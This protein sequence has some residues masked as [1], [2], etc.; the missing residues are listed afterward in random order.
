MIRHIPCYMYDPAGNSQ[1][2]LNAAS[3]YGF[4]HFV[5]LAEQIVLEL[6]CRGLLSCTTHTCL[7]QELCQMSVA[8]ALSDPGEVVLLKHRNRSCFFA[9]SGHAVGLV[10]ETVGRQDG[11]CGG[12]HIAYRSFQSNGVQAGVTAMYSGLAPDIRRLA[13]RVVVAVM[14]G[15]GTPGEGFPYENVNLSAVFGGAMLFVVENKGTA[16]TSY[17]RDVVAGSIEGQGSAFGLRAKQL[18]DATLEF[19]KP[20]DS[21]VTEMRDGKG[22]GM[23]AIKTG[24]VAPRS[25]GDD[26]RDEVERAAMNDRDPLTVLGSRLD[27][28][29]R[30]RM[31]RNQVFFKEVEAA[32]LASPDLRFDVV[33]KRVLRPARNEL[34]PAQLQVAGKVNIAPNAAMR[35]LLHSCGS[36]FVLGE[37]VH[38]SYGGAFKVTAGL[39]TDFPGKLIS[40]PNNDVLKIYRDRAVYPLL[41]QILA[42]GPG[43]WCHAIHKQGISKGPAAIELRLSD[44]SLFHSNSGRL[45]RLVLLRRLDRTHVECRF[46]DKGPRPFKIRAGFNPRLCLSPTLADEDVDYLYSETMALNR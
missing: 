8:R 25:K 27:P 12:Q 30:A 3:L 20:V 28:V 41:R 29:D 5:R 2:D 23:L 40:T 6:F 26:L 36:I 35:S 32:A 43:N 14:V 37:Y 16:Q 15:D 11:V 44:G 38:E 18:D 7:D 21:I 45:S 22:P 17:T 42:G 24:R 13:S 19:K 4:G 33:P 34:V 9:Y 1:I 31:A 10:A 46:L 39:A